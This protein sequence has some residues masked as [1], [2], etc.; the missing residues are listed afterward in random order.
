MSNEWLDIQSFFED[1]RILQA[2]TDLS[3]ALKYELAGVEDEERQQRAAEARDVIRR[4]LS[5]LGR[6]TER[7]RE[8]RVLS[9]NTRSKELLDAFAAARR[10]TANFASTV[11]RAG[12]DAGLQQLD[13][14]DERGKR[15]LLASLDELRRI[16]SRHQH[17]TLSAIVEEY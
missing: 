4:F 17:T 14:E 16:V 9:L 6:L 3:L 7:S 8:E 15:E 11:M 10:D 2:I 12:T 5:E 1:Q 13:S